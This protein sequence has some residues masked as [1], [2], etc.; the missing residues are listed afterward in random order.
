MAKERLMSIQDKLEILTEAESLSLTGAEFLELATWSSEEV[1]TWVKK[2]GSDFERVIIHAQYAAQSPAMWRD[3]TIYLHR[4]ETR[5]IM[6]AI[7]N[8]LKES[9]D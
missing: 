9:L 1:T 5:L 8:S 6:S 3:M 2:L 4:T 7:L